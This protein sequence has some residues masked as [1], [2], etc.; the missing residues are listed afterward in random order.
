[1]EKNLR[2]PD[3]KIKQAQACFKQTV[4]IWIA[5]KFGIQMVQNSFKAVFINLLEVGEH[6]LINLG[7]YFKLWKLIQL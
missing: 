5:N 4:R 6:L 2:I 1:M 3:I 7:K